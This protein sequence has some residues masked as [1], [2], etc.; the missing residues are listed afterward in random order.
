MVFCTNDHFNKCLLILNLML[1]THLKQVG[2]GT[3]LSVSH[4]SDIVVIAINEDS[5]IYDLN[6]LM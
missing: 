3:K 4:D 6:S 2:T 5:V 1:T